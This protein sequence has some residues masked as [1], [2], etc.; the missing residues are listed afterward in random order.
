M[1]LRDGRRLYLEFRFDVIGSDAWWFE[2]ANNSRVGVEKM[3][4]GV[5]FTLG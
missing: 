1:A 5:K 3:L 2:V 4:A